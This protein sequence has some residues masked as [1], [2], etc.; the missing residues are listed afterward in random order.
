[1]AGER[2]VGTGKALIDGVKRGVGNVIDTGKELIETADPRVI[3]EPV[4]IVFKK[5]LVRHKNN[6]QTM[7][8]DVYQTV[9]QR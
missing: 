5:A 7:Y 2:I 6:G 9:T 8:K 1:M 3:G 4:P